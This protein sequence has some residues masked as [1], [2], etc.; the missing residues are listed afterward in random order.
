MLTGAPNQLDVA[1][2]AARAD[3]RGGGRREALVDALF[4]LVVRDDGGETGGGRG[5][6]VDL[7]AEADEIR[8]RVRPTVGD[9]TIGNAAV[10]FGREAAD[11]GDGAMGTR[12]L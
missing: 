4:G 7:V 3:A 1:A 10:Q 6:D 12:C 8:I 11:D 5:A 2:H 9:A